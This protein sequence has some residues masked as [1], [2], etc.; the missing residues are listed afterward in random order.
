MSSSGDVTRWFRQLEEGDRQAVQRL[1]ER[2]YRRLVGL[3]R[4][5]LR[6]LPRRVAD[7]DDVALS[8][9]DSFIRGV[10]QGR[11]PRL[12]DRDDL[13]QILAMITTRKAFDLKNYAERERR[14]W[15]LEAQDDSDGALLRGLI[16]REPDPA[17]AA[18]VA[19]ELE[20]LLRLL[21]DE[22]LRQI[23]LLKLEGCTNEEIAARLDLL[24]KSVERRL[25]RVRKHWASELTSS[26]ANKS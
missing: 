22:E 25:S 6:G 12:E 21:P 20:R 14:D 17:F 9:F 16:G 10:E 1:W 18:Q 7:Q 15:R 5:K 8:A 19:E 23:V 2:Y 3:A 11:F 26:A 24:L 13:W 4:K